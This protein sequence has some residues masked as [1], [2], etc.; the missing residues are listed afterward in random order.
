[1]EIP[2]SKSVIQN[3]WTSFLRVEG[4]TLVAH[5]ALNLYYV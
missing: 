5:E 4:R 3:H 2:K 1:M